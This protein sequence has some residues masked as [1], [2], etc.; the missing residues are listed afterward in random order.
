MLPS[1]A[2]PPARRFRRS[3]NAALSPLG[4]MQ[5]AQ[6]RKNAR[7]PEAWI[8]ASPPI[9]YSVIPQMNSGTASTIT[10]GG[11]PEKPSAIATSEMSHS[12]PIHSASVPANNRYGP[13]A[14][15][16]G[17]NWIVR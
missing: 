14:D 3:T 9:D 1:I 6:L 10:D 12:L 2:A 7:R 5:H 8:M 17:R 11:V 13:E 15:K 16:R 4:V